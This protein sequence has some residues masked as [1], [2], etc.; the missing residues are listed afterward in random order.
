MSVAK[1]IE[2]TASSPKGFE[3]AVSEGIAR[4]AETISGIQGAWVA[5]QKVVVSD[6]RVVEY[7]VT[8][9]VSFLLAESEAAS[10]SSKGGKRKK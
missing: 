7:R 9:K 6:G 1:I 4:A 10:K 8:L 3:D 2:I 5:E